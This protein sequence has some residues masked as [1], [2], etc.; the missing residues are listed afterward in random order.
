MT[1]NPNIKYDR[2]ETRYSKLG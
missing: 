2:I 1:F